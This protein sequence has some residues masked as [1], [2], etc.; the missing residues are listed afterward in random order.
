MEVTVEE[1]HALARQQPLNLQVQQAEGRGQ[2]EVLL[3]EDHLAT[4]ALLGA[5]ENS[6]DGCEAKHPHAN[7]ATCAEPRDIHQVATLRFAPE[8]TC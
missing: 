3:E 4:A 7:L 1:T 2:A 8:Y 5:E 6:Q